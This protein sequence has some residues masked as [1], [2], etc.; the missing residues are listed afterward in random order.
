MYLGKRFFKWTLAT[1][2]HS[3]SW[4]YVYLISLWPFPLPYT[5]LNLWPSWHT[6]SELPKVI[7][8]NNSKPEMFYKRVYVEA[9]AVASEIQLYNIWHLCQT[10]LASCLFHN[11]LLLIWTLCL[12]P[13]CPFTCWTCGHASCLRPAV[14]LTSAV[15]ISD[16]QIMLDIDLERLVLMDL[17]DCQHLYSVSSSH[18]IPKT[19]V[20]F[21]P[22]SLLKESK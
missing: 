20:Q 9:S 1:E 14:L 7:F 6:S 2:L 11:W 3:V 4:N 10:W 13:W 8:F 15:G 18:C 12:K 17:S 19:D 5:S 16:C 21:R 22:S